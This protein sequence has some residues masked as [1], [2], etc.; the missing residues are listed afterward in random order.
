[1][2]I[3]AYMLHRELF[4]DPMEALGHYGKSRTRDGK[5][6]IGL[7]PLLSLF[8]CLRFVFMTFLQ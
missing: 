4:T 2:M 8:S 7:L 6:L 5:V 1:M 3:C